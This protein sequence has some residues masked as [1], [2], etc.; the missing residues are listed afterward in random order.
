MLSKQFHWRDLQKIVDQYKGEGSRTVMAYQMLLSGHKID[1]SQIPLN[2][3]RKPSRVR[4]DIK[5]T[6]KDHEGIAKEGSVYW[7]PE[8]YGKD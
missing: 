3:K 1:I 4:A 2:G 8:L 5:R 6:L 7:I